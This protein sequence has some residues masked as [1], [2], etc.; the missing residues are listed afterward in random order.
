MLTVNNLIT[1]STIIILL[2]TIVCK[3]QFK[4]DEVFYL[5]VIVD[6]IIFMSSIKDKFDEKFY[7]D[8]FEIIPNRHSKKYIKNK[9]C[10]LRSKEH[11]DYKENM[12]KRLDKEREM[13]ELNR[14]NIVFRHETEKLVDMGNDNL[15]YIVNGEDF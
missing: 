15:E 13:E 3:N 9:S 7:P 5:V 1:V 4:S 8:Y 2:M 11:N 12:N 14:N 6:L 10:F